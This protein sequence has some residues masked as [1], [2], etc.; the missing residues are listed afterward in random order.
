MEFIHSVLAQDETPAAGSVVSY[1]LPVNPLSHILLTLA[2]TRTAAATNALPLIID[3]INSISRIEVLYKGSAIFSMSGMDAVACGIYVS[4]F[5]SWGVNFSGIIAEEV[6]FTIP[7]PLGRKMYNPRECFPRSTRGELILQI[8][9]AAAWTDQTLVRA[10]IETVELPDAAPERYLR[11]TTLATTFAAA[12]ENDIELPIGHPISDVVLWGGAI[13]EGAVF[14]VTLGHLQILVNNQRRFYSHTNY[15]THHNMAGRMRPA[16]G[17]WYGHTHFA[18]AGVGVSHVIA[19][20]H[21]LQCYSH[22]P[23]DVNDDGVFALETAGK[24]DVVLR[25]GV[26]AGAA[27]LAV[28]VIPCELVPAAG[29]M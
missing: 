4:K 17:Y 1:D 16:P 14:A 6:S 20:D 21:L 28:R 11:M 19:D 10:Q 23:F 9:Y 7:I 3:V 15:E 29:G 2:C 27:S 25:I 8:T 13:P 26:D 12:G 22:L 24:S 18:A 5:E